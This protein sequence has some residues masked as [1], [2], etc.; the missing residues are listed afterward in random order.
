[1]AALGWRSLGA[2][3][4]TVLWTPNGSVTKELW[5]EIYELGIVPYFPKCAVAREHG[6]CP[7]LDSCHTCV[8]KN[9]P[10]I[11]GCDGASVHE[12]REEEWEAQ[13]WERGEIC[14]VISSLTSAFTQPHDARKGPDQHL[15]G[16]WPMAAWAVTRKKLAAE[17]QRT[18]R[19]LLRLSWKDVQQTQCQRSSQHG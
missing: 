1:M 14:V 8:S 18:T 6:K 17:L 2:E 4:T 7:N 11:F 19:S 3:N 5:P 12:A 16:K 13:S 10:I 9:N 15:K